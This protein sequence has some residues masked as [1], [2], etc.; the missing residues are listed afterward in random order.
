M[1]RS[2]VSVA[3]CA[4]EPTV[5]ELFTP[6]S[7]PE[8]VYLLSRTYPMQIPSE[9]GEKTFDMDEELLLP[10]GCQNARRLL[11]FSMNPYAVWRTMP[12]R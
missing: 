7:V 9:S 4:L 2:V 11:R 1:V 3:G 12:A 6:D 5:A 8:D 10:A